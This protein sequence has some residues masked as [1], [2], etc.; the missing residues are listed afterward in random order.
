MSTVKFG[1]SKEFKLVSAIG[2]PDATGTLY[3]T[4]PV[5]DV[6]ASELITA[7]NG[8]GG[9]ITEYGDDG[10][11][12]GQYKDYEDRPSFTTIYSNGAPQFFM[13]VSPIKLTQLTAIN[14]KLTD[15]ATS[16]TGLTETVAANKT[17][18]DKTTADLST[19]VT[20]LS[21]KVTDTTTSVTTNTSD[22]AT[23]LE[24][25]AELYE[26]VSGAAD[27]TTTDESAATDTTESASDTTSKSTDSA[28]A[29]S[30]ATSETAKEA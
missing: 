24:S 16:I 19:S 5:V 29:E 3:I 30:T 15:Q 8:Y 17:A 11:V 21:K 25:V 18:T 28:A 10:K 23:V 12:V 13:T 26:L 9:T 14:T 4:L 2:H 22:I 1:D 20:D 6:D 7:L 27:T